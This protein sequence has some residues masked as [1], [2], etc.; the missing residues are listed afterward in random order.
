[1]R[2]RLVMRPVGTI[3]RVRA[4]S[5]SDANRSPVERATS[6]DVSRVK[7]AIS[8]AA[9]RMPWR[10][11]CLPQALAAERWLRRC[12]LQPS[13]FVG[14][15]KDENGGLLAH[16]WVQCKGVTVVGGDIRHFTVLIDP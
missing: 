2:T 1:A 11:D 15:A 7:W 8:A 14:V 13:L 3:R 16:A 9:P 4:G 6:V 5:H 12:Y 10:C